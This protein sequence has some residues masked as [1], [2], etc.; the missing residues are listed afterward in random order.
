MMVIGDFKKLMDHYK[1]VPE[2][3]FEISNKFKVNF[4]FDFFP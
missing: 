1:L 3:L 4:S 2:L